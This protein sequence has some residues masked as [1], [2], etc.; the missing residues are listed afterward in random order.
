VEMLEAALASGVGQAIAGWAVE[1]THSLLEGDAELRAQLRRNWLLMFERITQMTA[2]AEKARR[3]RRAR[4][5]T[6]A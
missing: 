1:Y 4:H 5:R 2:K 3:R 6:D